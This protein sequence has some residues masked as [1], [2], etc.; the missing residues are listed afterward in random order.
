MARRRTIDGCDGTPSSAPVSRC[1]IR[2]GSSGP[3]GSRPLTLSVRQTAVMIAK[4]RSAIT[5]LPLIL[6]HGD[7]E[8]RPPV[9]AGEGH[10]GSLGGRSG[11][12]EVADDDGI[13]GLANL[14]GPLTPE[15][16]S[17]LRAV[18]ENP[19]SATWERSAG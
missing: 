7:P 1:G 6:R 5:E 18:I 3:A 9:A 12:V 14:H 15:F 10:V 2:T 4:E 11:T 8:Q 13:E 19:T 17:W 16:K